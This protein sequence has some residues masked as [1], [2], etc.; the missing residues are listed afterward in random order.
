MPQRKRVFNTA[1]KPIGTTFYS[2]TRRKTSVLSKKTRKNLALSIKERYLCTA[3]QRKAQFQQ[4]GKA[5]IAQ[6]VEHNR[7]KVGVAGPSPV[8]RSDK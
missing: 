2:K 3:F 4:A 6:L 5:A 1:Q 7:A 8:C